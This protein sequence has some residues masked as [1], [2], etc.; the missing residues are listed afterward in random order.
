M[1]VLVCGGRDFSDEA[2]VFDALD[3]LHRQHGISHV[4]HGGASGADAL[5]GAWARRRGVQEV[6]CPADWETHGRGAGPIRN[7]A[8]AAL[9][10]DKVVAFPGGKGT[11]NMIYIAGR[12]RIEVL[13]LR[14]QLGERVTS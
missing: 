12:Y 9:G 6:Q 2:Y 5:A 7:D 13:D 11:A 3:V 1:K 8:M 4:I 10:P 14:L